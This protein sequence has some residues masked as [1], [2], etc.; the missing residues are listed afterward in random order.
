MG[1]KWS[2]PV[3]RSHAGHSY[4]ERRLSSAFASVSFFHGVLPDHSQ[5]GKGSDILCM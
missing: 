2:P 3:D 5:D 4:P 1:G